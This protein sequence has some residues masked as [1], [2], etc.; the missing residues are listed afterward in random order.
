MKDANDLKLFQEFKAPLIN[1]IGMTDLSNQSDLAEEQNTFVRNIEE[2]ANSLLGFNYVN[3]TSRQIM[4]RMA[5][6]ALS[7]RFL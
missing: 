3:L 7:Q 4:Q 2:S 5:S 1:I 6:S